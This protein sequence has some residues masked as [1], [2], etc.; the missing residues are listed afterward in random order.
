MLFRSQ[1]LGLRREVDDDVTTEDDVESAAK[2]VVDHVEALERH[3]PLDLGVHLVGLAPVP[4]REVRAFILPYL[5]II[6]N[7]CIFI[8]KLN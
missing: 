1:G 6:G 7:N 3:A 8:P 2:G 5:I 4:G